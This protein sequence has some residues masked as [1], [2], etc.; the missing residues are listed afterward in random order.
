MIGFW[1]PWTSVDEIA[2][3]V[4]H[5]VNAAMTADKA[6]DDSAHPWREASTH[7]DEL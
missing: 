1:G 5:A 2:V 4:H 6:A 3:D 7:N